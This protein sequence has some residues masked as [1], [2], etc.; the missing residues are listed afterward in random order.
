[1][2]NKLF[3]PMSRALFGGGWALFVFTIFPGLVPSLEFRPK[4]PQI[5]KH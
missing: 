3:F 1:M 2:G 4:D 5:V